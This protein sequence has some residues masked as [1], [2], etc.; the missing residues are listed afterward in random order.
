MCTSVRLLL[1][2]NLQKNITV[3][4]RYCAEQKTLSTKTTKAYKIDLTQYAAFSKGKACKKFSQQLH[5]LPA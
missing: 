3:Y 5:I 2:L 4:L 1:P